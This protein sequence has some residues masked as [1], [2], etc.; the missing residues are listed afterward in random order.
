[1]FYGFGDPKTF[2]FE[3]PIGKINAYL[4]T[5]KD[6]IQE[7][8]LSSQKGVIIARLLKHSFVSVQ[9]FTLLSLNRPYSRGMQ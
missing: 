2:K 9:L 7:L 3:V 1:M 6:E 5:V 8:I 4:L